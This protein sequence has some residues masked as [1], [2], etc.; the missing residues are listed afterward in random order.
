MT[1]SNNRKAFA[2]ALFLL[3]TLVHG[4]RVSF[5]NTKDNHVIDQE[6]ESHNIFIVNGTTATLAGGSITAPESPDDGEDAVRVVDATF[7]AISGKIQ[8]GIGVGGTGVTITTTRDSEYP[9]GKATFEAGVEVNGGDATREKTTKG[10]DA[11]QVLQSGS[12]AEFYGGKFVPGAGCTIKTCGVTTTYGAALRVI[13]G[14]AIIKGGT[15]DGVIYNLAGDVEVHGC[16][17]YD[18]DVYRLKGVLL[19]GSEIDVSYSQSKDQIDP[20]TIV[21][22]SSLCPKQAPQPEELGNENGAQ[23]VLNQV[24]FLFASAV[25]GIITLH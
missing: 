9:P 22:D 8:G 23:S 3:A 19:D 5:G 18:K 14:K 11:V 10:G 2:A 13:Q 12:V 17:E 21:Y 6:Y 15:F 20:P 7:N 25:L 24:A 1:S 4:E 16:V